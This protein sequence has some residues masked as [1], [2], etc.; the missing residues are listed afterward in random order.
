MTP[1]SLAV[2]VLVPLIAWR[3]YKRVRRN[4]GRQRSKLWRHWC[5][6]VLCPL[7]LALMALG[8]LRSM[9]AEAALMGGIALGVGLGLYG[10]RLTRF[11]NDGPLFFYTPNP[12]LGIGLSMLLVGRLL[13]RFFQIYQLHGDMRGFAS[14]DFG[15]SPLTLA[16]VGIVFGYYTA[17]SFG[18]LR[19]RQR[20]RL[21]APV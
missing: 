17:Y 12:Y 2:V 11:E 4:I 15:R 16:M 8:A 9:E 21:P 1:P 13:Y 20:S 5:G 10:L 18:L 14:P 3:V 7:L 19:W 6:T